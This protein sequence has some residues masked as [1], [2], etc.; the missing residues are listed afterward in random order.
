MSYQCS[1]NNNNNNQIDDQSD[2][3]FSS[4]Y[5]ST[6]SNSAPISSSS[7]VTPEV[8]MTW[9]ND[10]LSEDLVQEVN[11]IYKF[12]I[13]DDAKCQSVYYLDLK[14]GQGSVG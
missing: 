6:G 5:S 11:A 10:V 14:N 2:G 7:E 9:V 13:V 1:N 12:V 4:S 3:F 8:L